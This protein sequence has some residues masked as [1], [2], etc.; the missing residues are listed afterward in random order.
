[1]ILTI[2]GIFIG[3][4]TFARKV[5]K[6]EEPKKTIDK[7]LDKTNKKLSI[8]KDN[9]PYEI[10]NLVYKYSIKV[11]A[12]TLIFITISY[13]LPEKIYSKLI[14]FLSPIFVIAIIL[15]F[16]IKWIQNHKKALKEYFL[17]FQMICILFAPI[18]LHF[19]NNY[20]NFEFKE[21]LFLFENIININIYYFQLIWIVFIILLFY[22]GGFVIAIPCYLILYSLIYI[23]AVIIRIIE[24]YIDQHILDALIGIITLIIIIIKTVT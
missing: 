16:S 15:S 20:L 8:Y 21:N 18:I 19:L 5:I 24:K 12:Y 23:S 2:L 4:Y 11:I 10:L 7:I 3:L 13:I 22:V 14:L 1:M 6:N 9:K 17:N